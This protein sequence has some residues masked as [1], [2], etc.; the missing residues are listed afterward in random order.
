MP[1]AAG[2][3]LLTMVTWAEGLVGDA[4]V[5]TQPKSIATSKPSNSVKKSRVSA[6]RSDVMFG[7]VRLIVTIRRSTR[8]PLI[9]GTT[10]P[11][12][13]H[14]ACCV[15]ATERQP[16]LPPLVPSVSHTEALRA[17]SG[18]RLCRLTCASCATSPVRPTASERSGERE[19]LEPR[20]VRKDVDPDDLAVRDGEAHNR[21][22]P[23]ATGYHDPGRAVHERRPRKAVQRVVHPRPAGHRFGAA[24][25]PGDAERHVGAQDDVRME[26]R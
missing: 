16:V 13:F 8:D 25:G 9:S 26:D 14:N 15:V 1:G 4:T 17:P 12:R 20:E 5:T 11:R 21:V 23:L 19:L 2:S 24:Q 18:S 6:A 22:G 10:W 7:T 3:S